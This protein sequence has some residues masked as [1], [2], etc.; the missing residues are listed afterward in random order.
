MVWSETQQIIACNN[1]NLMSN[2]LFHLFSQTLQFKMSQLA[3]ATPFAT[4]NTYLVLST[5][6]YP[7]QLGSRKI[8]LI[9]I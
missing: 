5:H 1:T 2:K 3:K 9:D 6:Y 4:L 8:D 7:L